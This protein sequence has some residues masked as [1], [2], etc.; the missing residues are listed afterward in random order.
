M[1]TINPP[2]PRAIFECVGESASAFNGCNA[3]EDVFALI[4]RQ[5]IADWGAATADAAGD[6]ACVPYDFP[7]SR[8]DIAA[9]NPALSVDKVEERYL[10]QI[11]LFEAFA[12]FKS[13]ERLTILLKAKPDSVTGN[14]NSDK[15]G[16][17]QALAKEALAMAL[18][19]VEKL[20]TGDTT[21]A[22][23]PLGTVPNVAL[24]TVEFDSVPATDEYSG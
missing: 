5:G 13:G 14:P 2:E 10:R 1:T 19:H 7:L 18:A 20:K 21:T 24:M 17:L 8:D 12:L 23:T 9:R 15:R 3:P 16:A 11:A 6:D 4:G 22:G